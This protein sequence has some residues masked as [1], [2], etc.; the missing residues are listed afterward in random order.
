MD[1]FKT[2]LKKLP[3]ADKYCVSLSGGVDS[4]VLL[5]VLS[6]FS[7]DAK[8]C[9]VH[10]NYNNRPDTLS[11][12]SFV[13]SFCDSLGVTL[14]VLNITDM[15][16]TRD[17]TRSLYE[18]HTR[19]LRFDEYAKHKCPVLL[20]HNYEDTLENIIS[21]I[22]SLKNYDNLKKMTYVSTERDVCIVRPFLDISKATIYEYAKHH[23]I[24]HLPD[25]TPKWSRRGQLR[26]HV[27]PT[28]LHYEPNF[29]KNLERL[30]YDVQQNYAHIRDNPDSMVLPNNFLNIKQ[31]VTNKQISAYVNT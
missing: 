31:K 14:H 10:V 30:A 7:K 9:A 17:H 2:A 4:M 8:L 18:E 5:H 25:S 20:G 29:L 15:V 26:D 12:V 21:N 19:K 11:E 3:S 24:P 1:T 28:L 16:R 22:S 13:Q 6:G 27:I 23:N